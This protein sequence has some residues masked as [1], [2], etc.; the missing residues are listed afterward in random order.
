MATPTRETPDSDTDDRRGV[1]AGA[2]TSATRRKKEPAPRNNLGR[3]LPAGTGGSSTPTPSTAT[4]AVRA[5]GAAPAGGET[6]TQTATSTARADAAGAMATAPMATAA[7]GALAAIA[8]Q[9]GA[10]APTAETGQTF[11]PPAMPVGR[12]TGPMVLDG[13]MGSQYLA[14]DQQISRRGDAMGNLNT[15]LSRILEG[16][17]DSTT[18]GRAAVQSII[19]E[20]NTALTALGS[21]DDTAAGRQLVMTTLGNA[22]QRAGTVLGQGQ[23]AAVVT[24]D[25]V[26]ALA[27]RYVQE[28]RPT[29]PRRRRSVTHPD[30]RRIGSGPPRRMPSGQQG[31]W[32]NE[33][34]Q[35]LRANG[36]DTSQISPADI[37]LIIQHESG[38]NPHAINNWDS[39]AAAGIP[40]KGLMQ[41]IDPTFN[42]YALPGHRDIWNPVDNIIAGVRY[43]V[44]RYGSVSEVPGVARVREGQSYVG[45]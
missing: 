8:A 32:I 19:A 28:S 25:R 7:L 35:I 43:A 2:A 20:V 4:P 14:T 44:D 39:N 45:Y 27:G 24:A 26:A 21:V 34:L 18:K 36:Y 42:S 16:A 33:A 41:T 40:S 38:G 12:P 17:A 11:A 5:P 23:A 6:T 1:T 3:T 10:G 9:Y 13:D 31:Q 30:S 22:L 37:A 15:E 29:R